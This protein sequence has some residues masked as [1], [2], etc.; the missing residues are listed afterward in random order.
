MKVSTNVITSRP[1]APSVSTTWTVARAPSPP[2]LTCC[3]A[4][5]LQAEHPAFIVSPKSVH[6]YGGAASKYRTYS[7]GHS[8]CRHIA[9]F[10]GFLLSNQVHGFWRGCGVKIEKKAGKFSE[11]VAAHRMP[12]KSGLAAT[13]T[14]LAPAP[15]KLDSGQGSE[16]S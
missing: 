13:V 7:S 10:S 14:F 5:T 16:G 12:E 9:E 4:S 1:A 6:E 3:P 2:L 8:V 11:A 15:T